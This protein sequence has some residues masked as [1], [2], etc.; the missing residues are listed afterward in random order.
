MR[1]PYVSAKARPLHLTSDTMQFQSAKP[2]EENSHTLL[3]IMMLL[4]L[5]GGTI[6]AEPYAIFHEL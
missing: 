2:V 6:D 3:S 1:Q 4:V 5:F